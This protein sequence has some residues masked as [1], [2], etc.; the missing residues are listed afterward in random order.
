M[1]K[2]FEGKFD[3]AGNTS[4]SNTTTA[5]R[6]WRKSARK[7]RNAYLQMVGGPPNDPG[8]PSRGHGDATRP[9]RASWRAGFVPY[10]SSEMRNEL[11]LWLLVVSGGPGVMI[12]A[13]SL[14]MPPRVDSRRFPPATITAA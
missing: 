12:G 8:N 14:S 3:L 7:D 9:T 13:S 10:L 1:R 2:T 4:S 5:A 11:V 6:W